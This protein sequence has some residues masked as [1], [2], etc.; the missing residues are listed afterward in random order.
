MNWSVLLGYQLPV[1]I[2]FGLFIVDRAQQRT[3]WSHWHWVMDGIVVVLS[4]LRT[5]TWVLPWSGH[6]VFLVY[7]IGTSTHKWLRVLAGLVLIE[8]TLIKHFWL[9]DDVTPWIGIGVGL[10]AV[11]SRQIIT[12]QCVLTE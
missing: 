12:I 7:A 2:V 5:V 11:L 10:I 9:S 8:A 3:R 6:A 1:F 4:A